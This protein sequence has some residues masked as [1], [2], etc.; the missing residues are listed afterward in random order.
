M[1]FTFAILNKKQTV[2]SQNITNLIHR[3]EKV[4]RSKGKWPDNSTNSQVLI[5]FMGIPK[6]VVSSAGRDQTVIIINI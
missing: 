5:N 1:Q 2:I 6:E 4:W 3:E